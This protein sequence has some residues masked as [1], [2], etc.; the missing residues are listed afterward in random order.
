[1]KPSILLAVLAPVSVLALAASLHVARTAEARIAARGYWDEGI[2]EFVRT[3]VA[4]SYVD[5]LSEAQLRDAFYAALDGYLRS[6]PDEYNHFIAPVEYKAWSEDTA[7]R[8]AGVGV[9]VQSNALGIGVAGVFPGGPASSGGIRIG[10]VITHVD[11][12]SMAGFDTTAPNPNVQLLKGREGSQVTATVSTPP[13]KD[14]PAGAAPA[15]RN[16]VLTRQLIQPPTVFPRR[17][18]AGGA[19]GYLRVSEFVE[20]TIAEF[21]R[22]LDPMVADG[23]KTVIVDLRGNGGGVLPATV[24]MADRFI[25]KGEIVRLQG[26]DTTSRRVHAAQEPGTVPDTVGLVVL[27]DGKSASASE[28]FAGCIQ[29]YRRGVLLGTRTYG[30]FLVQNITEI[31]GSGAGVKITT[32]RYQTPNGR[33]YQR[34]ARDGQAGPSGLIPDVVV[35]LAQADADKLQHAWR[36]EDD[37]MWGAPP[38]HPDVPEGWIDPQLQRALDLIAGNLLLQEI[39]GGSPPKNG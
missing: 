31:P 4:A 1:M 11:G 38:R 17:I 15:V 36:N 39:R 26:R 27:V 30:K 2:V 24:H 25:A 23:V 29:D 7:G 13:G 34:A 21:D 28:V 5:E 3:R 9:K 18:G 35:E 22:A 32:A 12:R 33:S 6:L 10:D 37:A 8:Y 19:V 14:A 20:T 16:V